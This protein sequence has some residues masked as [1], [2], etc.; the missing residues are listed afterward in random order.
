M[1]I[2]NCKYDAVSMMQ[3]AGQIAILRRSQ[4]DRNAINFNIRMSHRE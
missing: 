4:V 2:L 3:T 1:T